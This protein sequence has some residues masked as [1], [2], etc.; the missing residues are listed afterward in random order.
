MSKYIN[1]KQYMVYYTGG[2][3]NKYTQTYGRC[4]NTSILNS[5]WFYYTGG[6]FNKYTQTYGR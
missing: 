5:K 6:H 3:F 4:V 2:H 1:T